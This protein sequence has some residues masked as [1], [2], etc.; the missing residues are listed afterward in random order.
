M[1]SAIAE[2]VFKGSQCLS[3]RFLPFIE[4][5]CALMRDFSNINVR[6]QSRLDLEVQGDS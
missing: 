2:E 4:V 6:A 5:P 3:V 1:G